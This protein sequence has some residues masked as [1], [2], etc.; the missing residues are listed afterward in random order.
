M[1]QS[2]S[3]LAAALMMIIIVSINMADF[4]LEVVEMFPARGFLLANLIRIIAASM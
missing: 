1:N 2:L 4:E 3:V